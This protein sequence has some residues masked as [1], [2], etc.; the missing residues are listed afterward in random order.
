LQE[1]TGLETYA[2]RYRS[3]SRRRAAILRRRAIA[4]TGSNLV[5]RFRTARFVRS[6]SPS[7]HAARTL[8]AALSMV[9]M[10]SRAKTE[11][12]SDA[13]WALPRA[14]SFSQRRTADSIAKAFIAMS[15]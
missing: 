6:V 2:T 13:S 8:R 1:D 12:M 7:E 9:S 10:D 4:F 15:V 3:A 14:A 5:K 11:H